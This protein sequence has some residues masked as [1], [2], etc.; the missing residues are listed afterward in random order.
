MT[1]KLYKNSSLAVLTQVSTA[2]RPSTVG[3]CTT[4]PVWEVTKTTQD[5]LCL[6][7]CYYGVY[8]FSGRSGS[9]YRFNDLSKKDERKAAFF[10][11]II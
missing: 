7:A 1:V 8:L 2:K 3:R 6:L 10:S 4:K 9:Q 5:P 11:R